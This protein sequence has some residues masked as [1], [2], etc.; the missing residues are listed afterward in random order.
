ML[1][2]RINPT[3]LQPTAFQTIY[4]DEDQLLNNALIADQQVTAQTSEHPIIEQCQFENTIFTHNQFFRVEVTDVIFKNCDLSNCQFEKSSW[5][6]VHFIN[7]KLVGTT[8]D[9]S[10]FKDILFEAC[11]LNLA[12]IRRTCFESPM[13]SVTW[14]LPSVSVPVLSKTT[15]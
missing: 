11:N 5:Y 8:F 12:A 10:F 2:P 14:G 3:T 1:T 13:I 6:R 7:C 15:V 4:D 9:Q